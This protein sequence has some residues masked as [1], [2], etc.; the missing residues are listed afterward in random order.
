MGFWALQRMKHTVLVTGAGGFIGRNLV[1]QLL[2]E[3]HTVVAFDIMPLKGVLSE[4]PQCVFVQ[5][6]ILQEE[7][8]TKASKGCT[9]VIHLAGILGSSDYQKNY[10]IH[11]Q[12]TKN[13]LNACENNDINRIIA[14]SSIAAAKE[15]TGSYGTTK[16]EL[17]EILLNAK[18][19][20]ITILRPTMVL[21]YKGKGLDTIVKQVKAY[22]HIIPLLGTG[23]A[24]RQ[25]IW[26][27]DM[28]KLTISVLNNKNSFGKVYDV[29]G[30]EAIHFRD[31]VV[32][33]TKGL[34]AK[35]IM[36]PIPL[37]VAKGMAKVMEKVSRKPLFTYENVCNLA[38][39]ERVDVEILKQELQ[40]TST[41]LAKVLPEVLREYRE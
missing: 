33:V 22:P 26:I 41:P 31:F 30:E 1:P 5:G 18:S 38:H 39:D 37:F 12:G 7:S 9:A 8:I 19:V 11:V 40:F 14:Y 13:L 17:E 32:M 21:G 16:K 24:L 20:N 25:P 23:K 28:T 15:K 2:Q 29:G 27:N 10:Q 6:D 35:K 34:D 3:G 4:H 36:V